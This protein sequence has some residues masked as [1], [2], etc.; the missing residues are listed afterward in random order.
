MARST[1]WTLRLKRQKTTI[2]L[3]ADPNTTLSDLKQQLLKALRATHP[4][5][6]LSDGKGIPTSVADVELGLPV[7]PNDLTQGW[8]MI[9]L[10][11][12]DDNTTDAG[13]TK[14]AVS[15]DK[16]LKTLGIKADSV[17]AFRFKNEDGDL[18]DETLGEDIGFKVDIP[19]W[20]DAFGID[21]EEQRMSEAKK[22]KRD[23]SD[24]SDAEM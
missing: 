4:T 16:A 20:E 9:D 17:L 24:G 3:F 15:K 12:T 13:S 1:S 10:S 11:F 6:V 8:R 2:L 5:Q 22:S 18:D 19:D 14:G 7:E 23:I 21:A